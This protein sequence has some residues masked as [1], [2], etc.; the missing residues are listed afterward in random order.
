MYDA[1]YG[2]P[3]LSVV[4][5]SSSTYSDWSPESWDMRSLTMQ[6]LTTNPA[7]AQNVLSFSEESLSSGEDLSASDPGLA[8]QHQDYQYALLPGLNSSGDSFLLDGLDGTFGL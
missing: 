3:S 1:I 4:D 8:G 5:T 6:D 2:G 7:P